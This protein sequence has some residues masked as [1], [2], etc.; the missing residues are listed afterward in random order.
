M[1]RSEGSEGLLSRC[2][3]PLDRAK[4]A[5]FNR[6]NTKE[7]VVTAQDALKKTENFWK[8]DDLFFD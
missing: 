1:S 8:K 5:Y 2:F 3:G 4:E 7:N 6:E